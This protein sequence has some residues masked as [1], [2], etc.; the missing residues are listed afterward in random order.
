MGQSKRIS[1][2]KRSKRRTPRKRGGLKKARKYVSKKQLN[3]SIAKT[4]KSFAETKIQ[5]GLVQNNIAPLATFLG[6]DVF[7]QYWDTASASATVPFG[8]ALDCTT[9]A[10]NTA[11]PAGLRD[12]DYIYSKKILLN[13]QV[14]MNSISF[15][16]NAREGS[17][18]RFTALLFKNNRKNA[19]YGQVANPDTELYLTNSGQDVGAGSGVAGPP[20]VQTMT[21]ND[22][23]SSPMNKKNFIILSK[24][25]FTL[26]P[27]NQLFT[28]AGAVAGTV[29]LQT[30]RQYPCIKN[31]YFKCP[32]WKKCHY[33]KANKIDDYDDHFKVAIYAM[34]TQGGQGPCSYWQ[35]SLKSSFL[36]NDL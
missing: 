32:M 15:N 28:E 22:F 33:D 34:P 12:G 27:P 8:Q 14:I 4:I 36:F 30:G 1:L 10:K 5:S 17:P 19:P 35:S 31:I 13:L 3:V 2:S 7:R 11:T 25:V 16:A 20:A 6:S 29:G 9:L 18:I 24:K 26:S 21:L 23:Y